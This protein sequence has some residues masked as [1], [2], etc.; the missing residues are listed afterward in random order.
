[1]PLIIMLTA[2]AFC[3]LDEALEATEPRTPRTL[4]SPFAHVPKLPGTAF[5]AIPEVALTLVAALLCAGGL[6]AFRR[7][8]IA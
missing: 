3:L 4:L 6:A 2:P 7:R 1:V 8:D 5:T